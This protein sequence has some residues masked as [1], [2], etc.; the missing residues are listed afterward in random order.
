MKRVIAVLAMLFAMYGA[1][2]QGVTFFEGTFSDCLKSANSQ[3][4]LVFIDFYTKWCTYCKK[5]EKEVFP[6]PILK[7]YFDSKFITVKIDAETEQGKLLAQKYEVSAYPTLVIVSSNG[8]EVLS[9][10][11][12]MGAEQLLRWLR[13]NLGETMTYEEMYD[14]YRADKSND[15]LIRKLLIYA[16]EFIAKQTEQYKAE[17]WRVRVEKLY[18]SYRKQKSVMDMMNTDDFKILMQYHTEIGNNDEVFEYVA[19]NY[20][21]VI[22]RVSKEDVDGFLCML[23]M[24]L[25]N[26]KAV[27]GDAS[28]RTDLERLNGDLKSAY[29]SVFRSNEM[30]PYMCMKYINDATYEVYTNKNVQQYI[31]LMD[32][33]LNKLGDYA[34]SA[35]YSSAIR[36]LYEALDGKMPE[37]ATRKG[38]EWISKALQFDRIDVGE[39]ME[40]LIMNG[41][42][43]KMLG[44]KDNARECYKQAYVVSLQFESFVISGQIQRMIDALD[45]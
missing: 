20:D 32:E 17:Q 37:D 24:Q 40:L 30:D 10:E 4:K 45:E 8:E 39:Q 27:K 44:D 23:H 26:D 14:K 41:D 22:T 35:D 13:L 6:S 16:P 18:A 1:N 25:L 2:G 15:E 12:Y 19:A 5:M 3:H 36:T 31:L 43:Y 28:Y 34:L 9:A 33:Y 38:I 42:C 29:G 21:Q 7:E 11:G